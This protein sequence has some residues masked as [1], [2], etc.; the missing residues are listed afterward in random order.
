MHSLLTTFASVISKMLQMFPIANMKALSI[1]FGNH[2]P[3]PEEK[4]QIEIDFLKTTVNLQ[5]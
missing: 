3:A 4:F 5:L 2:R 1:H